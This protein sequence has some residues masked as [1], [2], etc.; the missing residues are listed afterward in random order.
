MKKIY[1]SIDI[2]SDTIKMLV[3]EMYKN[4]YNILATSSVPSKGV[5]RGLI[6]NADE[7]TEAIKTCL[8]DIEEMLGVKV[9]K[10]IAT[11]PSYFA[12]FAL[13]EGYTTITNNEKEV[14]GADIVRAL[15]SCVYNKLPD[16]RELVTIIP[17]EFGLDDQKGIKDPKGMVGIKLEAKAVMVTTPKKNIYSVV[18]VLESVG[19]E[20]IDITFGAIGDYQ[21]LHTTKTDTCVGA[22]INI[23]AETTNVSIFNKGVI[24]KNEVLNIGGKN[25]DNDLAYIYKLD[26][27]DAKE[28]KEQFAVASKRYAQINE[29]YNVV[30]LHNEELRLNQYEVS[31]V[32]MSRV[33]EILKLAKKQINLLTNKQIDYIIVSGGVSEL[34]GFHLII[35]EVLG[36]NGYVANIKTL[37]VRHNKF[38]S[39]IG[40]IKYFDE[41]LSLRGK[42]YSMFSNDQTQDL[43]STRKRLLNF[44]NDSVI[45]KVFGYF[46]DNN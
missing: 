31:E 33:I 16:D 28:I 42:D 24:I 41:K 4:K 14:K 3:C 22:I 8:K 9:D 5:K 17:L 7:V 23:G 29:T 20:V 36:Q 44:S 37:G 1:T 10:V 38:S 30:N 40:V 21:E 27:N 25:I 11:V 26:K 35:E 45:G 6:V 2:G 39:L 32:V 12:N 18:S 13:V 15:Q 34:P 43:I 46:F 19:L